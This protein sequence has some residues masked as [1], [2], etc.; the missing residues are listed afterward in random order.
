MARY[1]QPSSVHR[2][3]LA[4]ALAVG[5][6]YS[7]PPFRLRRFMGLAQG[8]LAAF[9]GCIYLLGASPVLGNLAFQQ[10][11][12][13]QLLALLGLFFFG[14]HFKDIKD[15][16]GDRRAGVQTLAT[17][18]GPERAYWV[19]GGGVL[20]AGSLLLALGLLTWNGATWAAFT[21]FAAGWLLL[22]DAEKVFW[23]M[24]LGLAVL[25]ADSVVAG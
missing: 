17:W 15:A 9:A 5:Y 19:C 21:V 14:A 23:V 25:F 12:K 6:V 1:S 7:A 22:R 3:P 20:V 8:V 16:E 24:L 10:L 4:M 13:G 11:D 2:N 18:L